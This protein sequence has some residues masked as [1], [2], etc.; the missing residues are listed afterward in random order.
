MKKI[1]VLFTIILG[2][3]L[4]SCGTTPAAEESKATAP[5]LEETKIKN[6]SS[7]NSLKKK[8]K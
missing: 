8:K 5:V 1:F 4:L 6:S 2:V 3:C 7:K